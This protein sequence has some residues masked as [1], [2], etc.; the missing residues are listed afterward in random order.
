MTEAEDTASRTSGL[1]NVRVRRFAKDYVNLGGKNTKMH[2]DNKNR[3]RSPDG[4]EP[5]F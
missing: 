4:G 3:L 2:E 1:V 5:L